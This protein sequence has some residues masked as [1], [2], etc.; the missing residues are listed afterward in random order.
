MNIT[1]KSKQ[2]IVE[3]LEIDKDIL[4][5]ISTNKFRI[6]IEDK[7]AKQKSIIFREI[8][9]TERV[10]TQNCIKYNKIQNLY[11]RIMSII[12]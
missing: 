5:N 11:N 10:S 3:T 1:E 4:S 2:N 12:N 6:L 8:S 9:D 7:L